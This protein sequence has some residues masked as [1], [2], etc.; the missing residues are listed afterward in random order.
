MDQDDEKDG[1]IRMRRS[2]VVSGRGEGWLDKNEEKRGFIM[3]RRRM[4]ESG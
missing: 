1:W 2:V 4:V 3:M